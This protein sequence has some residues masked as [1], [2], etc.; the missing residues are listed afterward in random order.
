[1]C[2]LN[3]AEIMYCIT[4]FALKYVLLHQIKAIFSVH[5]K[6]S[7]IN[8]LLYLAL[9]QAITFSCTPW[10]KIF[11]LYLEGR[12]MNGM[13]CIT[14]AAALNVVSDIFILVL[15][16]FGIAK[17]HMALKKKLMV[18]SVFAIGLL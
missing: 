10:Q 15:P 12:C 9:F 11:H 7:R 8:F 2:S 1:M 4:M 18:V 6:K 13:V 16:M 5:Y 14:A 3:I 17:L